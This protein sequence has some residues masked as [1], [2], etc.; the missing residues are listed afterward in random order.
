MLQ[1]FCGKTR[2]LC[3]YIKLGL[4]LFAAAIKREGKKHWVYTIFPAKFEEYVGTSG[5]PDISKLLVSN[6]S[7]KDK[8]KSKL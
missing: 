6:T 4:Y 3:A 1:K 2:K 7:S 5:K 8:E